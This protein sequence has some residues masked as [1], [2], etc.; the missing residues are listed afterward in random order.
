MERPAKRENLQRVR[1]LLLL[2]AGLG[3][4]PVYGDNSRVIV[5]SVRLSADKIRL[6]ERQYHVRVRDGRYW[7]DSFSGAWG[8]EGGPTVGLIHPGLALGGSLKANASGG[9]TGVF[10]NGREL[11]PYDVAGL[12]RCTSVYR[13]RYWVNAQGIGGVQGGPPLFNLAAL[14]APRQ[15]SGS[16]SSRTWFNADGSWSHHSDITGISMI[17]GVR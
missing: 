4:I 15:S 3:S 5:N 2:C 11:H 8:F 12:Q 14:C 9:T 16:K 7:Y 17:G 10:I 1:A 6:L 13:G